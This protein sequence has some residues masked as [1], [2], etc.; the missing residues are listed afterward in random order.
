MEKDCVVGSFRNC[1]FHPIKYRV[2][3]MRIMRLAGYMT[4]RGEKKNVYTF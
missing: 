2:I 1:T 3:K 4:Y